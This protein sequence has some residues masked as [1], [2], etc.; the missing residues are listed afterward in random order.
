[1]RL[2]NTTTLK[3]EEHNPRCIPTY[4]ILSHTWEKE[5]VTLQDMESGRAKSKAGYPKLVK[6]CSEA[7]WFEYDWIWIDTCCIDKTSSTEL[8]EAINSMFKWYRKADMCL[9]YLSDVSSPCECMYAIA[10]FFSFQKQCTYGF[11]EAFCSSRWFTRGWTLQELIAPDKITFYSSNWK[12]LGTNRLF[13]WLLVETTGIDEDVLMNMSHL[14]LQSRLNTVPAAAKLSW[15]SKRNT[16][17]EEDIA[18][19]L[20]GIFDGNIRCEYAIAIWRGGGKGFPST[21]DGDL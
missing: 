11:R 20:M 19:C 18:Y 8:S 17:R 3:V 7:K 13:A 12:K 4:A 15:A 9:A 10:G 1:M 21:P 14:P 5:E 2:L 16:A 6:S